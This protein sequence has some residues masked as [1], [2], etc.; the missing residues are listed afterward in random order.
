MGVFDSLL[1][2]RFVVERRIR[3][4]DGQG[5]WTIGYGTLG[6]VVGRIR[7][8]TGAE[9]EVAAAEERQVSHVLYTRAS[10]D[11]VRGDR[12]SCG[13]LQVEVLGIREPS[14]AGEHLE[15]DCLEVQVE[16]A[17]VGS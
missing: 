1:N 2:K 10:E 14:L 9:R 16:S 6:S 7:P 15:I 17:E 4:N 3:T 5:G 13:P 12:V 8:A 11:V